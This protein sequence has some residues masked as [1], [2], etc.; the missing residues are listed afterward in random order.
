[1]TST[2][3]IAKSKIK[4]TILPLILILFM[5]VFI[6]FPEKYLKSSYK[7]IILWATCVLPSLLP[8]FFLTT[9]FA[10]TTSLTKLAKL[11]KLTKFLFNQSGIC[12]YT[13][14]MSVLSGYPIGSSIVA[15]LYSDNFI[16]SDE[17]TRMSTLCSTSGPLFI[18]G[19][20]GICMFNSKT[21]G[22][23]ILVS[24][25]LSAILCGVTFRFY[26]KPSNDKKLALPKNKVDNALYESMYNSVLSVLLVGGFIC[27]SYII[28]DILCDFNLLI[29]LEKIFYLPLKLFNCDSF[30]VKGFCY[31]IIECTRGAEI[32]KLSSNIPLSVSLFSSVVSFGGISIFLQS[33]IYL[34]K[35]NVKISIF[36]LSKILQAIFSFTISQIIFLIFL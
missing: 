5:F 17:A 34:K 35:A 21:Y 24:H 22:F 16:D 1:M 2:N 11:N 29:I 3:N 31:G 28:S 23:I 19:T 12:L 20:V 10:K 15:S 7:G 8:F 26:G 14:I 27:I 4:H 9:L 25:I 33:I 32:L 13:F 18:V 36:V 6:L 30:N